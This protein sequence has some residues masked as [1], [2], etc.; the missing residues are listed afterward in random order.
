MITTV[1]GRRLQFSSCVTMVVLWFGNDYANIGL[2]RLDLKVDKIR[3]MDNNLAS[4]LCFS[5]LKTK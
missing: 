3:I 4:F 5:A 2:T 1:T